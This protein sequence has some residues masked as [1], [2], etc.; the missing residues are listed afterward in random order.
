[1]QSNA[2]QMRGHP[3][4]ERPEDK[5]YFSLAGSQ[6]PDTARNPLEVAFRQH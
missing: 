6:K 3:P 5:K 4:G 1:M 2:M